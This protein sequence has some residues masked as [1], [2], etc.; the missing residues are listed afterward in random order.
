MNNEI[1]NDIEIG[2]YRI[3]KIENSVVIF[4]GWQI[5]LFFRHGDSQEYDK[6]CLEL[7]SHSWRECFV[8]YGFTAE[9]LEALIETL[10]SEEKFI[11]EID[12]LRIWKSELGSAAVGTVDAIYLEIFATGSVIKDHVSG[13][14]SIEPIKEAIKMFLEMPVKQ[15][16][17]DCIIVQYKN[18][19]IQIYENLKKALYLS[20]EKE[21]DKVC[22]T[23]TDPNNQEN[24]IEIH[25]ALSAIKA[26]LEMFKGV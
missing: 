7:P 19:S 5:R 22:L 23:M 6:I 12:G 8:S 13:D 3:Q 14:L 4:W 17:G 20:Y 24:T 15:E 2:D 21:D 1:V 11:K 10:E 18:G 16:V 25:L 26:A 9:V